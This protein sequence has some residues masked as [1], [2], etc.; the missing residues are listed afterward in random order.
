V[1]WLELQLDPEVGPVR[2]VHL[3]G[4]DHGHPEGPRARGQTID[5]RDQCEAARRGDRRAR[6]EEVALHV[7]DEDGGAP[8]IDGR[9]H[10][11]ILIPGDGSGKVP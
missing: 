5:R 7:D 11:W 9:S 8:G 6:I 1:G 2:P 10:G 3:L 4:E